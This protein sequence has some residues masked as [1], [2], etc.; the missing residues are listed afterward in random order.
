MTTETTHLGWLQRFWRRLTGADR[1]TL[2]QQF[3]QF[4]GPDLDRLEMHEKQFPGYDLA[5][6]HRGMASFLDNCTL[7]HQAIGSCAFGTIQDLFA[8]FRSFLGRRERATQ[9]AYQR[10]AVDVEEEISVV[11]SGLFLAEMTAE[12]G[13]RRTRRS[14]SLRRGSSVPPAQAG[15]E[16]LAI[17][18]HARTVDRWD[19]LAIHPLLVGV[20]CRSRD[21]ADRFFAEL[22]ERRRASSIYRGKVIDPTL[23]SGTIYAIGFRAIKQVQEQDL[24]LPEE[25]MGLLQRSIV[26]FCRNSEKLERFQVELKR[27]ILLHGAPG[28]GKTSICLYLAGLFPEFTVCFVSGDRLLYPRAICEMARYLQPSMVV[29]EDIDLIAQQR[30]ENGLATVLGELMNQID[31]CEPAEQVLFVMNTNSLDRLESAV[32]NR[33]GRVDQ[34]I[35]IPLPDREARRRMLR[36]FTRSVQLAETDLEK[37]LDATQDMSPAMLKEIVKR[38]VVMAVERDGCEDELTIEGSDLLLAVSQVKELREPLTPGSLGFRVAG[39]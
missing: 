16:K 28:T 25:V 26:G 35:P 5:S 36:T 17:L 13:A 11:T 2:Y 8:S 7:Q 9:P 1:P 22:E 27:G 21:V 18:L 29:F 4:F 6:L 10:V 20:A 38:A 31:G 30:D 37:T 23:V 34:I 19:G 3:V 33:P 39:A 32:R 15:P 12:A 14:A 24:I